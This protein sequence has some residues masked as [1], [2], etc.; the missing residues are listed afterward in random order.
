MGPLFSYS[1]TPFEDLLY[2]A[3]QGQDLHIMLSTPG[4]DGETALRLLRQV[5]PRCRQLTVIVPNQAKSAGTLFV[6]GA[7]GIYM[8]PTSDLG[9]IDPQFQLPNGSLAPGKAIIAAVD[10]AERR[11][12]ENPQ[13]YPLHASLLSDISGLM[14]QEA[15]DALSRT[16]DLLKEA[17]ASV[18][19]RSAADVERLAGLIDDRL[20]SAP[21]N[22]GA[23]VSAH[24]A[25]EIGLPVEIADSAHSR[26][27]AVW[28]MWTKY[29]LLNAWRVYE[30]D[31]ASHVFPWP[32][33][34]S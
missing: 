24:D 18:P 1:I 32:S 25:K 16:G 21:T 31:H 12:Q 17:L 9:P 20:I 3:D 27:Q 5:R 34:P 10:E 28:R 23:T 8:G 33:S 13:T 14:V 6:L 19:G 26:W 22:H 30:G 29:A 11:V 2:D 7:D 15:R 4:G